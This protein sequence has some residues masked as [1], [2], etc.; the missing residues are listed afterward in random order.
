MRRVVVSGLGMVSPLGGTLAASWNNLIAGQSGAVPITAFDVEDLS[1]KIACLVPRIVDNNDN[2][3]GFCADEWMSSQE[4]GRV[5]DFIVFAI[6]AADMA[7]ADSGFVAQSE[8]EQNRAG[9]L[10]GSGIGGL[11]GIAQG[12]YTIRDKGMRRLSPFFV[13]GLLINMASGQV[14]IRHGLR[15]PNHSVVT[16]CATGAHA[17]GDAARL[18][19]LDD[20]DIMVAG[21]AE[22]AV[23]PLGKGY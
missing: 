3:P 13:P 23:C 4:Q 7:L 18:I 16:A 1:C 8:M 9:V 22:A 19:M 14:S 5:D 10:I 15:G 21:G 2:V 12:A 17:I 20:A 11:D 6:A